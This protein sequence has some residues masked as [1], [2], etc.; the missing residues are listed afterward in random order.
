MRVVVAALAV[1]W[2]TEQR[3]A[4]VSDQGSDRR[5]RGSWGWG[6]RFEDH[7]KSPIVPEVSF[8]RSGAEN[9]SFRSLASTLDQSGHGPI[10]SWLPTKFLKI[11]QV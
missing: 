9:E 10:L 2:Q 7:G 3:L 1:I 11:Q 8:I 4:N 5:A 6:N